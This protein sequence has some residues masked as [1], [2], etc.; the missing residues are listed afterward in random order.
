MNLLQNRRVLSL[1]SKVSFFFSL[2]VGLLVFL[3][4][5]YLEIVH[6]IEFPGKKEDMHVS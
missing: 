5:I 6:D 4:S 1:N 2:K 3:I